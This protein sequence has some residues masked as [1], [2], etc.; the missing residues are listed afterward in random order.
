MINFKKSIRYRFAKKLIFIGFFLNN[1]LISAIGF[2]LLI[3]PHGAGKKKI[4]C[5][6]KDEF[7]H[8]IKILSLSNNIF[9]F[10]TLEVGHFKRLQNY[11]LKFTPNVNSYFSKDIEFDVCRYQKFLEK[12]ILTLNKKYDFKI[13]VTCNFVYSALRP[14]PKILKK[15]KMKYFIIYKEGLILTLN[16]KQINDYSLFFKK[17]IYGFNL[18]DCD[19]ILVTNEYIAKTLKIISNNKFTNDNLKVCGLPRFD[20][21]NDKS[22]HNKNYITIF[23]IDPIHTCY[24]FDQ[25]NFNKEPNFIKLQTNLTKKY[26]DMIFDFIKENPDLNFIFKSKKSNKASK[27][28]NYFI[29]QLNNQ[30]IKNITYSTKNSIEIIKMS[31]LIISL[32]STV[33]IEAI[34]LDTK[35]LTPNFSQFFNH[36]EWTFFSENQNLNIIFNNKKDIYLALNKNIDFSKKNKFLEKFTNFDPNKS[37]SLK[38]LNELLSA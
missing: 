38:I 34:Y 27:L 5:L 19:K 15:N 25:R 16:N 10:L 4:L 32:P 30:N 22:L 3:V 35:V 33:V 13:I 14:L 20:N 6:A 37:F 29:D 12:I 31:K 24:K 7:H 21:L 18:I 28:K 1:H 9:S 11:F 26:Y 36:P 17:Y 8:D 23:E 2:D